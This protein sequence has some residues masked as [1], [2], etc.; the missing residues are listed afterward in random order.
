MPVAAAVYANHVRSRKKDDSSE[1]EDEE[2]KSQHKVPITEHYTNIHTSDSAYGIDNGK[3][4]EDEQPS[5][6]RRA[7]K[8]D[9]SRARIPADAKWI[10]NPKSAFQS[11]WD[12]LMMILLIYTAV[13]TP[14][15]TGFVETSFGF[16]FVLNRFVDFWFLVDRTSYY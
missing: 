12:V 13:V 10:I 15:E 2:I 16:L 4:T 6:K 3:D 1:S 14:F 5:K 8:V 11:R 9:A 7:T